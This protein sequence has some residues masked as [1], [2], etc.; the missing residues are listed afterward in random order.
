MSNYERCF[1]RHSLAE[2]NNIDIEKFDVVLQKYKHV[3]KNDSSSVIFDV[4]CNAGSFIKALKH[5]GIDQGIHC[6]EPHPVLFKTVR[7]MYPY[8]RMNEYCLSNSNGVTT[9]N[10]PTWS[11]G[12]SSLINRPVFGEL[13]QEINNLMVLTKTVDTYCEENDIHHIDFIKIDVEGAEKMVLEGA[14][15]LLSTRNIKAG[16]FEVGQTLVDAG[17]STEE[18]C[19]L[20]TSYGYTLDTSISESDI[21]FY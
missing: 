3:F 18:L 1:E 16:L 17:S 5:H 20:V 15:N 2:L 11:V 19:N 7:D 8:V 13:G 9:M 10:V 6:F 14:Y 21:V 12:L 4:G